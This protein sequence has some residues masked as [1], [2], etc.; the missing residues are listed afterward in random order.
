MLR[1]AHRLV[2]AIALGAVIAPGVAR[3]DGDQD[4]VKVHVTGDP[5]LVVERQIEG[6]ELWE[7]LCTGA[8]DAAVPRD[9]MYRVSGRAVRPSLPIALLPAG[10][11]SLELRVSPGY[12]AAWVGGV[13][14]S[15]L[16][17]VVVTGGAVAVSQGTHQ[18]EFTAP[19]PLDVSC[20]Q[21]PQSN[22]L[23]IG[24]VL[25]IAVGVVMFGAGVAALVLGDHTRVRQIVSVSPNGLRV[26]F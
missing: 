9:G 2:V 15:T 12:R 22:A 20:T 17:P 10:D 16:G 21:E 4:D 8:C 18:N 25:A 1:A 24:G 7:S 6:T 5:H 19:C 23:V 14:L 3:A 13:L 26:T 11:H